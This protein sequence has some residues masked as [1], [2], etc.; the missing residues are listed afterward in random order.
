MKSETEFSADMALPVND[1]KAG[2]TVYVNISLAPRNGIYAFEAE[3]KFDSDKL[4]YKK[5][6]VKYA[7]DDSIRIEKDLNGELLVAF[8]QMGDKKSEDTETV[9]TLE[10]SAKTSGD[11]N[12]TLKAFKA[13]FSDMTYCTLNDLEKYVNI[14]VKSDEPVKEDRPSSGGGGGGRGG[15][16]GGS[17]SGRPTTTTGVEKPD[18][19][20]INEEPAEDKSL[21]SD[22]D[23]SFWAY[24]AISKLAEGGI[25]NGYEDNSFK[26]EAPITRAEFAKIMSLLPNVKYNPNLSAEFS[27][28]SGGE[29]YTEAVQKAAQLGIMG[30]DADGGFRPESNITREEASAVIE[31][32][33]LIWGKPLKAIRENCEFEDESGISDFAKHAV[34]VLYSAGVIN[35]SSDGYFNPRSEITRAEAAAMIYRF[36]NSDGGD[37]K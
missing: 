30:G 25:I 36:I 4:E 32:G 20:K 10:F 29:W 18:E 3:L 23:K 7:D 12:V 24:E 13:V 11:S 26:P 22:V 35:G 9:V 28:V 14:S 2:D 8:T 31:R 16:G 15:A 17:F 1:F 6:D 21:Y 5:S 33:K 34:D 37:L 27:D 19:P